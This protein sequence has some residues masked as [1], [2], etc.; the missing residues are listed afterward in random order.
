M[1]SNPKERG[2]VPSSFHEANLSF[3][4]EPDKDALTEEN[5]RPASFM[6]TKSNILRKNS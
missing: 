4:P 6:Y 3:V 5:G 1:L 2:T